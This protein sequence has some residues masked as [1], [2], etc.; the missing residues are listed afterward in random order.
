MVWLPLL[1]SFSLPLLAR[2]LPGPVPTGIPV[3]IVDF[4]GNVFDLANLEPNA[5]VQS[6]THS[7]NDFA[8]RWQIE[9]VQNQVFIIA[10]PSEGPFLGTFL[11]YSTAA[12]GGDPI[13]SQL[14]GHEDTST[15]EWI[16][17]PG[18][19]GFGIIESSSKLFVTSWPRL[20]NNTANLGTSTPLT[21]QP[22]NDIPEQVFT[23]QNWT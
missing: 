13:C 11:S 15:T 14:F 3:N 22:F 12:T 21:L 6:L 8:Q 19:F 7:P 2:A 4:Q 18:N 9:A 17:S 20:S 5:P 23:F 16:I 10:S 1:C